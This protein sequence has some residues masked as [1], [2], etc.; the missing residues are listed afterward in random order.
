MSPSG[1][2]RWLL[3]RHGETTW[4]DSGRYAGWSDVPLSDHGREQSRRLGACL[5]CQPLRVAYTS[6]LR[7]ARETLDVILPGHAVRPVVHAVP[8]LRELHFG[9]WEGRSYA[10]IAADPAGAAVLAG[11]RAAPGGECLH[12][13]AVRVASFIDLLQRDS[14]PD[15]SEVASEPA[16]TTC[17][18]VTHGGPLRVLLCLLLGLLPAAHWRFQVDYASLTEVA[19]SPSAGARLVR[20][21]D[22]S[23]LCRS[24]LAAG[25]TP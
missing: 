8:D 21:N 3:V 1:T 20:L 17:L 23:H 9:S 19:W 4:T 7:R 22:R 25:G 10:E 13:L 14:L 24:P 16:G 15:V 6:P 5:S 11:Q 18:V 2:A 12:D